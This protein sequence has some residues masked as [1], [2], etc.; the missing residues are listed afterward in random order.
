MKTLRE[1][2]D[3]RGVLGVLETCMRTNFAGVESARYVYSGFT[4]IISIRAH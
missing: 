3:A 2:G 4:E 1:K